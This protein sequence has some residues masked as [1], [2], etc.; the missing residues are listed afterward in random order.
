MNPGMGDKPEVP[1]VI[2]MAEVLGWVGIVMA[3][4]FVPSV[5]I[6]VCRSRVYGLGLG[7]VKR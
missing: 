3:S 7:G 4:S 1:I 2:V 6:I 5:R